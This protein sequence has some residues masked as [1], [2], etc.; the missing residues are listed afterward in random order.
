MRVFD[1][2][3]WV[4]GFDEHVVLFGL[5]ALD[6]QV[7]DPK[8]GGHPFLFDTPMLLIRAVE[9]LIFLSE[10]RGKRLNGARP[11]K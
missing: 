6:H 5:V 8:K 7:K 11:K 10:R 9:R 1:E 4:F 2:G 3:T